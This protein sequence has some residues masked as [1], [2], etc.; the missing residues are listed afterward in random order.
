LP[1]I[2]CA[3]T[4]AYRHCIRISC[5]LPYDETLDQGVQALADIIRA[6]G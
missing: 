3:N 6:F 2:I 1:G 4:D 5:G